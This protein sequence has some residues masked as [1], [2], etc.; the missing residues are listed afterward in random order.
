M[1]AVMEPVKRVLVVIALEP[2]VP[3]ATPL[4]CRA[5]ASVS[6]YEVCPGA[7]KESEVPTFISTRSSGGECRNVSVPAYPVPL[8]VS[9]LPRAP[10]LRS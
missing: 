9:R 2:S 10:F 5:R 6:V 3:Y 1:I 7:V 8:Y 4:K